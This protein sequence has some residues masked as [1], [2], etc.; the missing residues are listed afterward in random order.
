MRQKDAHF[1]HTVA[2]EP[3]HQLADRHKVLILNNSEGGKTIELG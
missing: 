1:T 2:A 3:T